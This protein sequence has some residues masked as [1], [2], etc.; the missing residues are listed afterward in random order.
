MKL[1]AIVSDTATA[2][3]AAEAGATVVQLRLK[4]ATTREVVERGR[5]IAELCRLSGVT[6]VVNDDLE[7]ALQLGA[8]GVHLGREDEG[9]ER[10]REEHLIV[11]RSATSPDEARKVS[12]LA[13]YVGA[14]PV[15]STPT[16]AD[17]DPAI[18]LDGL[19][20]ICALVSVPVIA[21]GGIDPSNV[22][23]CLAAGASGVAVVRA[24]AEARA[25]RTAIDASF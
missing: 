4:G 15:W 8:D 2:Q 14:G 1:H 6:F 9:A 18:G 24:V 20:E 17:A 12:S 3:L 22:A 21:I 5:E 7:A 13:D 16:K 23:E 19:A 25:L 11:G 10:A